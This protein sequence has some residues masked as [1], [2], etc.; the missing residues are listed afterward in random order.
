[1]VSQAGAI[2]I[3]LPPYSPE[4]NPT[5]IAFSRVKAWIQKYA[6]KTF[7][8]Y[9][10]EI[11]DICLKSCVTDASINIIKDRGYAYGDLERRVF[12]SEK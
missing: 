2:D 9:P 12:F 5:E 4:L 11:M 8:K 3:Y 10:Q 6:S 1:M 7:G